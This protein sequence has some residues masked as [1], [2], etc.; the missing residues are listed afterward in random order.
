M[1]DDNKKVEGT[2]EKPEGLIDRFWW[3]IPPV[4][5][6]FVYWPFVGGDFVSFGRY[7]QRLENLVIDNGAP[8]FFWSYFLF[9]F[10]A[11]GMLLTRRWS[12]ELRIIVPILFAILGWF[13]AIFYAMST[14]S[15]ALD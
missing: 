10:M 11:I 1:A 5:I 12:L 9:G 8:M 7:I 14:S 15:Y 13:I 2:E 3:V 6:V 4:F